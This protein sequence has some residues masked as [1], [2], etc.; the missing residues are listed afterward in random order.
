M[1]TYAPSYNATGAVTVLSACPNP[2]S[3]EARD[4]LIYYEEYLS[5]KYSHYCP[6]EKR[7]HSPAIEHICQITKIGRQ[8]KTMSD[9]QGFLDETMTWGRSKS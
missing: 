6:A 1:G 2:Q 7:K 9:L 3:L 5:L 8:S 4:A